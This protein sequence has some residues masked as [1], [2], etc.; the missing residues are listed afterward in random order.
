M[1]KTKG[2]KVQAE[3]LNPVTSLLYVYTLCYLSI[4]CIA[5][6]LS[7]PLHSIYQVLSLCVIHFDILVNANGEAV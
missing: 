4:L 2:C 1:E 5:K 6:F 7:T 3:L